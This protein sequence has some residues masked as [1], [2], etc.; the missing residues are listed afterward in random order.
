MRK[1][2]MIGVILPVAGL[3]LWLM[4]SFDAA[5]PNEIM[6]HYL[7][8]TLADTGAAN[9]VTAIYLS[10]RVYDTLFEA[11]MLLISILAIIYFSRHEE[12]EYEL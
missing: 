5:L 7:Q 10:Y 11:L 6:T 3:V 8:N 4:T 2:I 9:A 12:Y 1:F